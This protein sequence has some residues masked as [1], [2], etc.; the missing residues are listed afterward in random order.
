MLPARHVSSALLRIVQQR[1]RDVARLRWSQ[2]GP[3][4]HQGAVEVPP[5]TILVL[6]MTTRDGVDA[7]V[8][9]KVLPIDVVEEVGMEERV[10]E[11]CIEDPLLIIGPALHLNAVQ[12]CVPG[13]IS[14]LLH[15]GE[16]LTRIL[17][18]HIGLG[19]SYADE[20]D[21]HLDM[22]DPGEG[23]I[24]GHEGTGL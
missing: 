23:G 10:I 8:K 20:G 7:S 12:A 4:W 1:L 18:R 14:G 5:R 22:D 11:R 24:K 6:P 17:A 9:A 16:V 19:V 2:D 21:A 15:P 3:Q 13:G